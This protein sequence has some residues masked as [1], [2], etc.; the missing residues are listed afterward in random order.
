M[1]WSADN[2]T[3]NFILDSGSQNTLW[4]HSLDEEIPRQFANLGG[5]EIRSFAIA[6]SDS[7][8]GFIRGKWNY[9]VVL[10]TGLH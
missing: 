3:L 5:E 10:V 9:D 8:F 4:Q 6:P 2:R 7:G 1:A